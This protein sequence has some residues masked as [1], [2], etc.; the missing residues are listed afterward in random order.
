MITEHETKPGFLF[1]LVVIPFMKAKI[2]AVYDEGAKVGTN[3]I[4][5]KGAAL[6]IDVDDIR[7]LFGTGRRGQYLQHNM[8]SLD[9]EA[10]SMDAVVISHAHVDHF[11]G[12]PK[13]MESRTKTIRIIAPS[14]AWGEKKL[15]GPTGLF[16]PEDKSDLIVREDISGWTQL[17]EH[18][19]VSPPVGLNDESFLVLKTKQGL[20]VISGCSH[21]GVGPV[22][23][24]VKDQFGH[25]PRIYIGGIHTEKMKPKAID[26]IA[27]YFQE[28]KCDTLYLNHCTGYT[29][30]GRLR[31]TLSLDGVKD[32]YVGDELIFD[33]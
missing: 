20:G 18:L 13:F 33:I 19:F 5:A 6:V 3:L 25:Y 21:V 7:V 12:F 31:A 24:L 16:V 32:F 27:G 30:L 10:D 1:H 2:L 8:N 28:A 9:V 22:M 15:F 29:G 14:S 17:S 11:G 26:V 4:G 23:N